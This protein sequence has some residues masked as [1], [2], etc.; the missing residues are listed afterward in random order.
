MSEAHTVVEEVF[1]RMQQC[2]TDSGTGPE[3]PV[4]S[5]SV[6]RLLVTGKE[7]ILRK[8]GNLESSSVATEIESRLR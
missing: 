4:K 6:L 1:F 7:E 2:I 5:G 3:S 8:L